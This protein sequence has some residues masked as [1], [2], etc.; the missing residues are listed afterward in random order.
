MSNPLALVPLALAAGHG[1]AGPSLDDSFEAQQLVAAGLTLLQRSA[2]LVRAL[3]GRRSMILL[4]A[5]PLFLTALAASDG[6][7][8][9]LCPADESPDEILHRC[10]DANV[11]AVLTLEALADRLPVHLPAVFL[12]DAPRSARVV[13]PDRT[14]IVDLGSHHGLALEGERDAPGRD[15][16]I[17]VVQH[18]GVRRSV[19][20]R[21]LL[22]DARGAADALD[23][24]EEDR[25]LCLVPCD[26][27]VALT[28]GL[29]APLLVGA[30]V[31]ATSVLP[32]LRRIL[33]DVSV[34]VASAEQFVAIARDA[35]PG[36]PANQTT[37]E[38][39][40][41]LCICVGMPPAEELSASWERLTGVPLSAG[42][43]RTL[44]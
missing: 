18:A 31:T 21:D 41:K 15:E 24:V 44:R 29:A 9:V 11:G 17:V 35:T 36:S 37:D 7:G 25:V 26:D 39:S 43:L 5:S 22:A 4:P 8:A 27:L 30:R 13:T 6:R 42:S 1:H 38:R 28:V 12:D 23:Y 3:A 40:L 20:H 33:H 2:P 10:R 14:Q 34:I 19:T 32:A 16:E